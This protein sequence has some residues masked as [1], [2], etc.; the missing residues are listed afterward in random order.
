LEAVDYIHAHGTATRLN[1]AREAQLIQTWFPHAA[2]SSSKGAIGHT[3]GASGAIGAAL[4]LKSL[5]TQTLSPTVGLSNPEY[6]GIHWVVKARQQ[7]TETVLCLSF[8]FG[9]Q[10]AAIVLG[11]V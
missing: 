7:R 2:V 10:N 9:G 6:P 1:D 4:C 11:L 3:L 5:Q 8:G